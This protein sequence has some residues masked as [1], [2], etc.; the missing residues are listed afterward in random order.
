MAKSWIWIPLPGYDCSILPTTVLPCN[1]YQVQAVVEMPYCS[2][3][4]RAC[5]RPVLGIFVPSSC[6]PRAPPLQYKG[7]IHL[8]AANSA[9][10]HIASLSLFVSLFHILQPWSGV[11][12]LQPPS[13]ASTNIVAHP[14]PFFPS[15]PPPPGPV[16][17][18]SC[19]CKSLRPL[20]CEK[21]ANVRHTY[22]P[23]TNTRSVLIST[24]TTT[25]TTLNHPPSSFAHNLIAPTSGTRSP[26]A[27]QRLPLC[28]A[29]VVRALLH[30]AT[31]LL[32]FRG[33]PPRSSRVALLPTIADCLSAHGF[34]ETRTVARQKSVAA[35]VS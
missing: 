1:T 22:C 21:R 16:Q 4:Y 10:K 34:A 11:I 24:T 19:F 17:A 33:S 31:L 35:R 29:R 14:S 2:T 5:T 26:A 15:A 12:R 32:S 18:R 7:T 27:F 25:A 20:A 30:C 3:P 8:A 28:S 9:S 6:R 13:A 23:I